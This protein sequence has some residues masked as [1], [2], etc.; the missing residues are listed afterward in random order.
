[1]IGSSS[2]DVEVFAEMG[3]ASSLNNVVCGFEE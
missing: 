1:M 2:G 3:K